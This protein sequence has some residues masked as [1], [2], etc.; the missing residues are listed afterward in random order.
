MQEA[1][2]KLMAEPPR[3]MRLINLLTFNETAQYIADAPD[4]P[5]T[6]AEAYAL[7]LAGAQAP[8][9]QV[10]AKKLLDTRCAPAVF[11][12][13]EADFER[14]IIVE[15]PTQ[16]SLMEMAQMEEYQ[17]ALRHRAAAVAKNMTLFDLV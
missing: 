11:E 4:K 8:L 5:I 6:G 10:G 2:Q 12:N 17:R 3:P 7:Y 13:F 1:F 9:A 15:Y 16:Q 14:V